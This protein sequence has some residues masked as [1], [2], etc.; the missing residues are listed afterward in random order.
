[1]AIKTEVPKCGA[2]TQQRLTLLIKAEEN[3]KDTASAHVFTYLSKSLITRDML[4]LAEGKTGPY[5]TLANVFSIPEERPY[6]S[7]LEEYVQEKD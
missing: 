7:A 1:M 6:T 4:K 2:L 5:F 3:F